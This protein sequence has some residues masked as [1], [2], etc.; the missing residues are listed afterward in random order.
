MPQAAIG[1]TIIIHK[2]PHAYSSHVCITRLLNGTWLAAFSQSIQSD[3]YKHPPGDP[4]FRDLI[5]RSHDEGRSWDQP[6][7][8]PDY[9]WYGVEVPGIAQIS[10]G[11]VLLNQ[12]RFLWFPLELARKLTKSR[13]RQCCFR[14]VRAGEWRPAKSDADWEAHPYPYAR[15]DGGA[16]VHISTDNGYTW[17]HTVSVS[18]D[19]YQG[20]FSPK[21]AIELR[22]KDVLLAL[23][24]HSYDPLGASFV[25]RSKDR[26]RTWEKPVEAA[27]LGGFPFSEPS[28]TETS[29]GKLLLMSREEITGFIYQSE[30]EDGGLTWAPPRKLDLWGCPT[31]CIT[32]K[33]GRILIVYGRRRAPYGIRASLSEDEG[34]TWGEEIVIRD[35]F[36]NDNLGYP[37]VIEYEDAK[38]FTA[39]YGEDSDGITCIQGTYF[40]VL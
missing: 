4:L 1:G 40:S 18:I 22:N 17:D 12:W 28:V 36:P 5:V 38:L 2:T 31:H 14:D 15:A 32:L 3:P 24:S 23:G 8:V 37:S 29:A 26:G 13:E 34:S 19:P 10:T 33:D 25:V 9:D 20:A 27:R 30:S 21:G 6:R 11:E 7:V 16:Y 35:D 39:Y